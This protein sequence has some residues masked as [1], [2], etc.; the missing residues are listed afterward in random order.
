MPLKNKQVFILLD[1]SKAVKRVAH[2][3]LL[4]KHILWP[5]CLNWIAVCFDNRQ[6]SVLFNG[7]H[8]ESIL[9]FLGVPQGLVL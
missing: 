1:Y 5:L 8:S 7:K 6:Q 2:V 3:K 4:V 9:V